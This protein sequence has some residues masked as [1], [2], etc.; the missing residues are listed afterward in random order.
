MTH[1]GGAYEPTRASGA[2]THRHLVHLRLQWGLTEVV[3]P[4]YTLSTVYIHKVMKSGH[5]L[6]VSLPRAVQRHLGLRAGD[7]IA[8]DLVEGGQML[9]RKLDLTELRRGRIQA[10]ESGT[11]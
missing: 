11:D 8:M 2:S 6:R 9:V 3:Y 7:F 1:R 4:G 5:T 10:R